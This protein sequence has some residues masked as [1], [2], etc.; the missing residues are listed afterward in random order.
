MLRTA[1]IRDNIVINVVVGSADSTL[2]Y[3]AIPVL[4]NVSVCPGYI[5]NANT[6]TFTQPEIVTKVTKISK[7]QFRNKFTDQEKVAIYTTANTNVAVKIWLDDLAAAEYID[8]EDP[9]T[10]AAVNA[11]ATVGVIT[12]NRVQEILN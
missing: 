3:T 6:S 2:E 7:L 8:L 11:L 10:I 4:A 9:A 1:L 12:S 5:Y